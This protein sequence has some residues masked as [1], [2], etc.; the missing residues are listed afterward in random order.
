MSEES[1][2]TTIIKRKKLFA[3]DG[4]HGGAWKVAYADFVTA[5]M[6]FFMLMWI[7]NATTE[8]QR[9]G[10]ADYFNP[11]VPLA[12]KS[13]GGTDV[14]WGD[15]PNTS[16]MLASSNHGGAYASMAQSEA[17][18]DLLMQQLREEIDDSLA[19]V[20]LTPEGVIVDLMDSADQPV[21]A[22]GR[23]SATARLEGILT[24]ITPSLTV[25]GRAIKIVGHTDDLKFARRDY[26][27]WEL[28][29]DRANVARRVAVQRG[30]PVARIVEVSGQA[31]RMPISED[32]SAPE[33]RRISILLFNEEVW[34][35][36]DN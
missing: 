13:G 27:N 34:P 15:S 24:E 25:S 22:L 16:D 29:A 33:N 28:S 31:D 3:G 6:A 19:R 7:L 14:L 32:S 1:A 30:L 23:A 9:R 10:L 26:S 17:L 4:H 20:T 12:E 11:S 8:D 36:E 21:F 18:R 5:M 35:L 2:T